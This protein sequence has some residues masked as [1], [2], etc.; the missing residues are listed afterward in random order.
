MQKLARPAAQEAD[1]LLH[2]CR[3][4]PRCRSA[5]KY[6]ELA[7]FHLCRSNTKAR[8]NIWV[9]YRSSVSGSDPRLGVVTLIVS[10]SVTRTTPGTGSSITSIIVSSTTGT[11]CLGAFLG[12]IFAVVFRTRLFG[13]A[14]IAAFLRAGLAL[15]FPRFEA[16]LRVALG[17]FALAIVVSCCEVCRRQANLESI[18]L[19]VH[20]LLWHLLYAAIPSLS[21]MKPTL[22]PVLPRPKR[23]R[24]RL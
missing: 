10:Y 16:F 9:D 4:R 21:L 6:D 7:P 12:A 5:E 23:P 15:A 17:F 24:S 19:S 1:R 11:L 14:C 2:A 8:S 18:Q 22:P 20:R 13:V 3:E